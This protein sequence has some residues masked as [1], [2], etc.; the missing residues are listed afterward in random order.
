MKNEKEKR[1]NGW[2]DT[3]C[4]HKLADNRANVICKISS[5]V[6]ITANAPYKGKKYIAFMVQSILTRCDQLLN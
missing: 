6:T 2:T 3:V 4:V 5:I 1:I